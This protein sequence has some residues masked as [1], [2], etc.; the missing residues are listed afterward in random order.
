MLTGKLSEHAAAAAELYNIPRSTIKIKVKRAKSKHAVATGNVTCIEKGRAGHP[1][2]FTQ[3]EE[4]MFL[5]TM[6]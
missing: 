6:S 2:V 5:K 3:D 4:I 1:T